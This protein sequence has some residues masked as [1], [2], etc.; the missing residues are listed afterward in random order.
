MLVINI[1]IGGKMKKVVFTMIATFAFFAIAVPIVNAQQTATVPG[2]NLTPESTYK[3]SVQ[4]ITSQWTAQ[5][6]NTFVYFTQRQ[7]MGTNMA[8]WNG[9][10]MTVRLYDED[11]LNGDDLIKTY[12]WAFQG[13]ALNTVS[14]TTQISNAFEDS[15]DKTGEL[16]LTFYVTK[17]SEDSGKTGQFFKYYYG[18]N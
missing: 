14:V 7:T 2:P 5:G 3:T 9:R 1:L 10:K 6:V 15:G 16:Y 17:N 11:W 4:S 12:T 13:R 18:M 8:S